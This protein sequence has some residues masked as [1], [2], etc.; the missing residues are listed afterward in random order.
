MRFFVSSL[1]QNKHKHIDIRIFF[2]KKGVRRA[3][4]VLARAR[5]RSTNCDWIAVRHAHVARAIRQLVHDATQREE[6]RVYGWNL[7]IQ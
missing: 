6:S 3:T 7:F 1:K 2:N 4:A 5:V